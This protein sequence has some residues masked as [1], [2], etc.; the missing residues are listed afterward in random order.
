MRFPDPVER[1]QARQEV[2]DALHITNTNLSMED[3]AI[4]RLLATRNIAAR[5]YGYP[6]TTCRDP[7]KLLED[8]VIWTVEHEKWDKE[9]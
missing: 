4:E 5:Q 3:E 1:E 7:R 2:R 8:I 9:E 6:I